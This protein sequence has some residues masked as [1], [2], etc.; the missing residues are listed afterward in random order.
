MIIYTPGVPRHSLSGVLQADPGFPEGPSKVVV[1]G[2]WLCLGGAREKKRILR[3][4]GTSEVCLHDG[5]PSRRRLHN[6]GPQPH[7]RRL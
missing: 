2:Q 5:V 1:D 7:F 6:W 3:A 4:Q